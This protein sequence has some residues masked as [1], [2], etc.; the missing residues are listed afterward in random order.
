MYSDMKLS[1]LI[2]NWSAAVRRK[3]K[4]T[5]TR[6][7]FFNVMDVHYILKAM[8]MDKIME[9]DMWMGDWNLGRA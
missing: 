5:W 2:V 1:V 8:E 3:L 7:M 9:I 4:L 6:N